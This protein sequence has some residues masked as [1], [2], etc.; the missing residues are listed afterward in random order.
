MATSKQAS[1]TTKS[2]TKSDTKPASKAVQ[3]KQSY[4]MI[5]LPK[6]SVGHHF[7]NTISKSKSEGIGNV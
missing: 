7:A 1:K 5:G 6:P 2:K 3:P 4:K